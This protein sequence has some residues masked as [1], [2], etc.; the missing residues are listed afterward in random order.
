MFYVFLQNHYEGII[1]RKYYD[2]F[3]ENLTAN[4]F[5]SVIL[6]NMGARQN[7]NLMMFGSSEFENNTAYSTHPIKFFNGKKDGFQI[8]LIGKAGYKCLVHAA[9]FGAL[10]TELTGRKVVFV[11]SPQWFL[12][13]GIDEN[14]FE[15]NTS[16]LQVY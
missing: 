1:A 3:G 6:Q 13:R 7:D 4:K 11:L 16:E 12:K 10:G 8:N 15:A 2:K 5:K 14:T 9:N